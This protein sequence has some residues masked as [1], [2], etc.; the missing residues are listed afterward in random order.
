MIISWAGTQV[1]QPWGRFHSLRLAPAPAQ[2]RF[3]GNSQAEKVGANVQAWASW[4]VVW[5]EHQVCRFDP[6]RTRA[7]EQSN[8]GLVR[9][10]ARAPDLSHVIA[11]P[12]IH[13]LQEH[14][15]R[16]V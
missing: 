13:P 7:I 5:V 14:V 11:S 3:G 10:R 9:T 2:G 15:S 1:K 16:P 12:E 8:T 6:A 4:M